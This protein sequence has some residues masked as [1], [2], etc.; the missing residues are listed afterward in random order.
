MEDQI[1]FTRVDDEPLLPQ[2]EASIVSV[3]SLV[4]LLLGVVVQTR[5]YLMLSKKKKANTSAAIDQLYLAHNIVSGM[6]HPPLFVYFAAKPF[7]FPMSDY[8]GQPGCIFI[9]LFMD[10]FI[11]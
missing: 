9:M 6:C 10:S 3:T 1:R 5:I 11:R 2:L 7:L 4:S 8:I